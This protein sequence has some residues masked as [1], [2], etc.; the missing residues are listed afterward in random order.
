MMGFSVGAVVQSVLLLA[1]CFATEAAR[2]PSNFGRCSKSD[3]RFNE[4]MRANIEDAI[5]KLKEGSKE[6][7]LKRFD[8]LDIPEL[9]IGE[10]KGPVNVVQHFKDV[11]LY[12]L[13]GS[14]VLAASAD[15]DN[16]MMYATSVTPE[17]RLQGQ[18]SMKGR[19]LL[20]PIFGHGPCNV[21][22]VNTKI[23]HTLTAEPFEKKGQTYWSFKDYTV[24]LRPERVIF[25]F[26]N[27]FDGDARLGD[28]IGK[29]LNDNWDEVFT[30][31]R[32][33]YEKSFGLIFHGLANRVFTRVPLK[34]IFLE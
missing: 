15:F 34:D 30:D 12:G 24:T 8:P 31:V 3:P 20:L 23:N 6:L 13:T 16:K 29:V 5:H 10:G 28:E 21:T 19:V 25:K 26:D 2:L 7:G 17:L 4:C 11:E 22:L 27:L 32:D 18:Y 1:A 33:G 14:K 9:V